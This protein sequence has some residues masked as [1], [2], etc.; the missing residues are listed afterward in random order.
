MLQFS[1]IIPVYNKW[2]LTRDCLQSLREHTPGNNFEVILADNASSDETRAEAPSLGKQLFADNFVHIRNEENKNFSGACNQ[3]AGAAASDMLFFLNNDT[4]LTPNWAPP[5]LNA[6]RDDSGLGAVG[7]VL[8]YPQHDLVQHIGAAFNPKG[9]VGHFYHFFPGSHPLT[10]KR[11]KLAIITAA[12]LMLRKK[13]FFNAGGFF[14]G[15]RN[16]FEDVELSYRLR[17]NGLELSVIGESTI[18]HLESQTPGRGTH[19]PLN[20]GL[21]ILRCFDV[22][23]PDLHK[24]I[25]ADGYVPYLD[26]DL[27][28]CTGL[29]EQREAE[30]QNKFNESRNAASY[31]ALLDEEPFWE[32]GYRQMAEL[33][34]TQK[35]FH[36]ANHVI[37]RQLQRYPGPE[38]F[39][40]LD[41]YA[42]MCGNTDA[43]RLCRETLETHESLLADVKTISD[44]YYSIEEA[45]RKYEDTALQKL[46]K[47]WRKKHGVRYLATT[48]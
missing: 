31:L 18:Y 41:H 37:T 16:G 13:D 25:R 9:K 30:M 45:V 7:P 10:R 44:M 14:E 40:S 39:K 4:L 12:A 35:N 11:R 15:Y 42:R 32:K 48:R 36:S 22:R 8:L 27:S 33:F 2:E 3:G 17:Q 46:L 47:D 34:L 43:L 21:L 38:T 1:V 5:L 6:L 23:Q 26:T 29:S 24:I 19:E 28:L 20:G